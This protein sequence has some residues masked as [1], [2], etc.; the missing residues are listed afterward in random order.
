MNS[1]AQTLRGTRPRLMPAFPPQARQVWAAIRRHAMKH[2]RPL[3]VIG[4]VVLHVLLILALLLQPSSRSLPGG[5]SNGAASGA[6]SGETYAAVDLVPAL[7]APPAATAVKPSDDPATD[8][9]DTP[10]ETI[11]PPTD[12]LKTADSVAQLAT[13]AATPG[14][15]GQT[16]TTSGAGDDL[17]AAIAP[18]WKRDAGSDT[19]PVALKITFGATGGLAKPP[20][21]VRATA[22]A[23]TPQS[24]RSEAEALSALAQCGAYPMAAGRQDVEVHFPKPD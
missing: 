19:L 4:S 17:W 22:A 8:A 6:G 10:P 20:I 16:G 12:A 23:I 15:A 7:P 5:G 9:L 24:L 13:A 18:C 21:I 2:R 11:K 3:A 1:L 14:G